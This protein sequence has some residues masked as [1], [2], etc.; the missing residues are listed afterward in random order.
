MSDGAPMAERQSFDELL[1]PV[2]TLV[3]Q[4]TRS[5]ALER[6]DVDGALRQLTESATLALRVG[7]ASVW[8]FDAS[9]SELVCLDLFER[10]TGSHVS[11][12]VI[13]ATAVPRYFEALASE[14]TI[15]AYDA[16]SDPR[17]AELADGY[18]APLG[19]GAMLDAPILLDGKLVGVVC[20]EHVGPPRA[21]LPWEELVAGTFADFAAMVLG[22]AE[23]AEQA[24]ALE[25]MQ[26]SRETLQ[27]LFDAAPVPLVLTGLADGVIRTCN[28]RAAHMFDAPVSE[29]IGKRAPDFYR[30]PTERRAFLEALLRDGR[31]DDFV[32]ELRTAEGRPFWA[33]LNARKLAIGD[34]QVFM[35][36]F[37]DLTEQKRV[38][39]QLRELAT[40]DALTGALNRRRL[41]E[42]ATEELARCQRYD[43]PLAV[44]ML[45]LD[46]FKSV[47]DQFGHLVGDEV[48][49][50]VA[51]ALRSVLR[52]HD[53]ASRYGGEEFVVLLPETNLDGA[54]QVVER[55]REAVASLRI[56]TEAGDVRLTTSAGV[57]AYR[58]GETL[59][60]LLRRADD[61][62]YEAK[63]AG[64]DRVVASA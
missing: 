57:V 64:R 32:T 33:Q 56:A 37:A 15:A 23:R 59:D 44:A 58:H 31:V 4:L 24:R 8:R 42:L 46:H 29:I 55:M 52:R 1:G 35:V 41:Y 12:A 13:A 7:R 53:H 30:D 38:E 19:I 11:G 22:A 60:A 61:A 20:H 2:R 27:I 36:G 28:E 40:T 51:V 16:L 14:R 54:R 43:R 49:R 50:R 6:G 26:K 63:D 47:N 39:A 21:F 62:L 17:T 18:L 5:A 25:S 3:A 34:E 9:R 10:A 45:D 48:L